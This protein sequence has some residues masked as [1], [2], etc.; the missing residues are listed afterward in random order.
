MYFNVQL[1]EGPNPEFACD[2][3]SNNDFAVTELCCQFYTGLA[4]VDVAVSMAGLEDGAVIAQL[5][6]RTFVVVVTKHVPI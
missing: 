4:V 6:R 3:M 2:E 5:M 1:P